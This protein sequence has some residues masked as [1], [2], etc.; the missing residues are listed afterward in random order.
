MARRIVRWLVVIVTALVTTGYVIIPFAFGFYASLDHEAVVGDPPEGFSP[1]TLTTRDGVSLET[2]Y[3]PPQN[4]AVIVLVHGSGNSRENVRDYAEMLHRHD[5][6]VLALDMRGHGESDGQTNLLGWE[7]SRDVGAAVAFLEHQSD[8]DAIGGLGL[9]LGGEVLLGAVSEFPAI[10]AVVSDGATYRSL[11]ELHS[12]PGR[13]NIL[14]AIPNFFMYFA[15]SIFTRDAPPLP[16]IDSITGVDHTRF[17]LIAAGNV[18]NEI[19]YN[20]LFAGA[21][22][23]RADLW[24]VPDTAHTQAYRRDPQTYQARVIAFFDNTLL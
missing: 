2:W 15:V 23:A 17:L 24:I 3:A 6:G 18:A 4:G 13:D 8:V 9:S 16:I 19:D 7:G 12:L 21:V 22:G 14:T 20:T 10:Q 5:Y 1:L 11:E